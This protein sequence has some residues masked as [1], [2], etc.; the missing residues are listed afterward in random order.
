MRTAGFF[1]G[2]VCVFSIGSTPLQAEPDFHCAIGQSQFHAPGA[3]KAAASTDQVL[4]SAGSLHVLV[5]RA[6][7]KGEAAPSGIAQDYADQLFDEDLPGSFSHFYRTMSF[8]QLQISGTVLPKRYTSHHT[9]AAYQAESPTEH[10]RYDLF[11]QE[12]LRQVD[13]EYDLGQFDNDGSDGLPNSGDDDGLVDYVFV[14]LRSAPA[15]F[16][17]GTADGIAGLGFETEYASTDAADDGNPIRVSGAPHRGTILSEGQGEAAFS[18]TVGNMAHEFGHGLGLP[19]LYDTSFQDDPGQHPSEDSAGIGAWGLMGRGP[20]GWNGDD[21][22]NP[23]CAWSLERLGWI[24]R[25]NERLT[26]IRGDTTSLELPDLHQHG[27]IG[28][29]PVRNRLGQYSGEYLLLENRNRASHYY[30]RNLPAEGV[31]IWHIQPSALGNASNNDNEATKLVDLVCADGLFREAGRERAIGPDSRDHL[32]FWARD[33]QYAADHGGNLGDATDPFDGIHYTR[34]D[35]H[36]AIG[37][38]RTE[39]NTGLILTIHRQ[40]GRTV[41]ASKSSRWSGT[42]RGTAHWRGE[43]LVDGDLRIAPEGELVVYGG[44]R[45]RF[46]GSDRIGSGLDPDRCELLVEGELT[47]RPGA[48]TFE[49]LLPGDTW[50]G[51][52]RA[53]L[54]QIVLVEGNSEKVGALGQSS[55]VEGTFE[56]RDAEQGLLEPGIGPERRTAIVDEPAA[57]PAELQLLPN[58]PNPFNA[59]TTIQYELPVTSQTRL[60]V[61]NA[62]GQKVRNL[63]DAVLPAGLHSEVWDG[64]SDGGRTVSSGV[65]FYQ[66]EVA[67]EYVET[68]RMLLAQ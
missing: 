61:Y 14:I 53:D 46:A 56:I 68:R 43:I 25:D 15:N 31:L 37:R 63:V 30:N 60:V 52:I 54:G 57:P 58:F 20:H 50:Y 48:V 22:P 35:L 49:A 36:L 33:A 40:G 17:L 5:V 55:K 59:E 39:A 23:F 21:G 16:L 28:R 19:D 8:G 67:G 1:A 6:G 27:Q 44:T 45:V 65:Y 42:I 41:V 26:E 66:L 62:V 51:I 9:S 32:D 12:I 4:P 7:F 18:Q 47:I 24:G 10:G 29:I 64:Q 11:V 3:A 38:L 2:A 34:F 13:T